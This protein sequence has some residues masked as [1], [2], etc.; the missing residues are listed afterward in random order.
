M[1]TNLRLKMV[2][3]ITYLSHWDWILYKSRKDLIK[4]IKSEEVHAMCPRGVHIEELESIYK[5]VLSWEL[6]RNKLLDIKGILSLRKLLKNLDSKF[7]CFTLKTG[8]LFCL[9]NLFLKNKNKA[10][11]S[12][13]GL[14][15][16]FSRRIKAKLLRYLIRPFISYLFNNS[17]DTIIFQNTSD[18]EIFLNF[19]NFTSKTE[20]IGSSGIESSNFKKKEPTLNNSA[21]K[22]VILVSRLLYDKGIMDYLRVI[23]KI[24]SVD[25][26]FYLAGERD[27][28]N[29][30]NIT[31]KD[32]EIILKEEKLNYLGKIDTE[33]ELSRFDISLVM[34]SH[35]GF[36]RILLESLYVG[37]Y[38]IAYRIQ[39][40]EVMKE[41]DNLELIEFNQIDKFVEFIKSY[42][43]TKNNSK[44]RQLIDEQ[45]SS[46]VTASH[47]ER[48]YKELDVLN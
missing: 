32:M 27:T 15:F 25:F 36:S 34:S 3:M 10:V 26:E 6:N 41:F 11:L 5:S 23:D 17:F 18:K 28:G 39:G 16:L 38:C 1:L 33:T 4:Y 30:Q 9:A 31:D 20:I 24:D 7:H 13:T 29:P 44:N 22:K 14:G 35:E 2:L 47:F 42:G 48:I 19:S 21:K 45:Y 46:R 37:L 43:E 12:I 8:I 40:T